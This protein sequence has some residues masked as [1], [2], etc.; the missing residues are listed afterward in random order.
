MSPDDYDEENRV[1][2]FKM[3]DTSQM[4]TISI[5][6]DQHCENNPNENFSSVLEL[7]PGTNA[8]LVNIT[9]DRAYIVIDDT[10]KD[11]CRK[12]RNFCLSKNQQNLCADCEGGDC[13][14]SEASGL[15]SGIIAAI[16]VVP[17]VLVLGICLV[18]AI[19]CWRRR[20]GKSTSKTIHLLV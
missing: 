9:H 7:S 4:L 13:S 5:N 18:V 2:E 3:G 10:N 17:L 8:Q 1:I 14:P 12:L 20:S 6:Q 19:V 15:S 16:V 11:L